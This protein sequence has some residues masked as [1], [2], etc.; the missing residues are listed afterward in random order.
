MGAPV[1]VEAWRS[2]DG[3]CARYKVALVDAPRVDVHETV[4][5]IRRGQAVGTF[6]TRRYRYAVTEVIGTPL[7][8]GRTLWTAYGYRVRVAD[9]T[10]F[11]HV[12]PL[13]GQL[14]NV[15]SVG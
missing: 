11:G 2:S 4:W 8:G 13:R 14:R 6:V 5:V 7:P 15:E 12:T 1:A 3:R 9:G 10:A